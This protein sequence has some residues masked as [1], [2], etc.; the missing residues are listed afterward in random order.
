LILRGA[1]LARYVEPDDAAVVVVG[2]AAALAPQL[3]AIGPFEQTTPE[4][5]GEPNG[6]R[7]VP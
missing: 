2:P 7:A 5:C 4:R 3:T 6:P 1:H